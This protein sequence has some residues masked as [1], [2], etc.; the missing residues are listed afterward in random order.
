MY[1]AKQVHDFVWTADPDYTNIQ[2]KRA[3]GT[4][5][6]FYYQKGDDTEAWSRLPEIM[7]VAFDTLIM[8]LA[9]IRILHIHLFKVEMAVWNMPWLH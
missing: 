7:D 3:D 2:H 4:L 5:L 6:N 9:N 8:N 1:E